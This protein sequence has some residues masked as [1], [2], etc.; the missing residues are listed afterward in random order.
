MCLLLE[1][2]F[3]TREEIR[4]ITYQFFALL[5]AVE[6]QIVQTAA[7]RFENEVE[8]LRQRIKEH[9]K[10]RINE[11]AST[12]ALIPLSLR[13]VSAP[14]GIEFGK[15]ATSADMNT[16]QT[17]VEIA[18]SEQA[19]LLRQEEEK[20]I[21]RNELERKEL[22]AKLQWK[23]QEFKREI[24]QIK[25]EHEKCLEELKIEELDKR[26]QVGKRIASIERGH[27]LTVSYMG[28]DLSQTG[29]RRKDIESLLQESVK[30][31]V[32]RMFGKFG[33][34]SAQK[35]SGIRT[36]SQPSDPIH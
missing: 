28:D 33:D 36:T 12:V 14:K 29:G 31:K 17:D 13:K 3:E 9:L 7:E 34:S 21:L 4:T 27:Q 35:G 10:E 8:D 32:D 15:L 19:L 26:H 20:A 24:Q 6:Q 22:E 25:L 5:E 11:L 30:D 23:E 2:V 18:K 1:K 16:N